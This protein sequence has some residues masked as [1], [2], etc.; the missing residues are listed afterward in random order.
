MKRGT[1]SKKRLDNYVMGI[2]PYVSV[3]YNGGHKMMRRSNM[4]A[5]KGNGMLGTCTVKNVAAGAHRWAPGLMGLQNT[6]TIDLFT[7]GVSVSYCNANTRFPLFTFS[8][9]SGL[10]RALQPRLGADSGEVSA[11]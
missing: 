4:Y 2:S 1:F 9:L 11:Q 3:L 5:G 7:S 8:L 6:Q 10:G